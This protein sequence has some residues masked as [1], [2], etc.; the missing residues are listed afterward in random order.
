MDE[1]LNDSFAIGK[2]MRLEYKMLPSLFSTVMDPYRYE[3]SKL[4]WEI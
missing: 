3:R 4:K 1:E 2:G